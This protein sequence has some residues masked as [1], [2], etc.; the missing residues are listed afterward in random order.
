M[1]FSA[2]SLP[3]GADSSLTFRNSRS[4]STIAFCAAGGTITASI[5]F[6]ALDSLQADLGASDQLVAASVSLFILG[7]GVFP[8]LWSSLS[9]IKGRRLCYISAISEWQRASSRRLSSRRLLPGAPL[10]TG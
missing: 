3:L 5:Y 10:H 4:S 2:P 9:E 1:E 6:P 8:V 7:Q